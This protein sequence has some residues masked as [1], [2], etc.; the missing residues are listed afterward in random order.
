VASGSFLSPAEILEYEFLAEMEKRPNVAA[1][2]RQLA[3][4]TPYVDPALME[5]FLELFEDDRDEKEHRN[6]LNSIGG[7]FCP[8]S[9]TEYVREFIKRRTGS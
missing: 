5:A 1:I 4:T 7:G 8:E 6:M 3:E 2:L 9:A